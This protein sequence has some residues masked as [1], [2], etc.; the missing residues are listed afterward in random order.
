MILH[1]NNVLIPAETAFF[2]QEEKLK[3]QCMAELLHFL[4]KLMQK[5]LQQ[6]LKQNQLLGMQLYQNN[7]WQSSIL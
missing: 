4:K 7:F 2:L 6:N 5:N 1:Q 3:V